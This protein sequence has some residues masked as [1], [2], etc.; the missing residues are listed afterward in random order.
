MGCAFADLHVKN[1]STLSNSVRNR[2]GLGRD[3][4]YCMPLFSSDGWQAICTVSKSGERA[5]CLNL[6][7][8]M[9][10]IAWCDARAVLCSPL[11]FA[12]RLGEIQ[13]FLIVVWFGVVTLFATGL[14][15]VMQIFED[16]RYG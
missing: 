2:R 15:L 8:V 9:Q 3:H 5:R 12:R 14:L 10:R 1:L 4:V 7:R 16:F 6:G 11:P 13:M